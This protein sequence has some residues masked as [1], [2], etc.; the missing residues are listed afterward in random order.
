MALRYETTHE[1]YIK[2]ASVLWCKEHDGL[3]VTQ[4]WE[5]QIRIMG[6][7]EEAIKKFVHGLFK[8][9]PELAKEFRETSKEKAET[10]SVEA[11]KD[12][13]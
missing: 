1:Y 12:K 6:V 9:Y 2:D 3:V 4:E 13:D 5:D 11:S 10:T 7:D 8:N